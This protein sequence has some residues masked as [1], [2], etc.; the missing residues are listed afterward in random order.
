MIPAD[1]AKSPIATEPANQPAVAIRLDPN[2]TMEPCVAGGVNI[3]RVHH[4]V[5]NQHFQLGPAEH[6][7]A[8]LLDRHDTVEA[9]ARAAAADGVD[10]SPQRLGEFI[11]Q[12]VRHGLASPQPIG[13]STDAAVA[14][15]APARPS[16][17][18]ATAP[19]AAAVRVAGWVISLRVPLGSPHRAASRLALI[20]KRWCPRPV[21]WVIAA[22][23]LLT[24]MFAAAHGRELTAGT[25]TIIDSGNWWQPL[26]LWA[27]MKVIHEMGHAVAAAGRGVRVGRGGLMF[28]MMAP[29]AYVDVSDAW[30]LP[31]AADRIAIAAAGIVAELIVAAASFWLWWSIPDGG[32]RQTALSVFLLAGPATLLVNANPL[33]RLDGYYILS[34]LT[35][36]ANLRDQGRRL[37][38]GALGRPLGLPAASVPLDRSRRRIALS[39]AVASVMFQ[40]VWMG[41][42]VVTLVRTGGVTAM[43]MAAAAVALWVVL[44]MVRFAATFWTRAAAGDQAAGGRSKRSRVL[45]IYVAASGAAA[46]MLW[47]P[48][49]LPRSIP[50]VVRYADEQTLRAPADAFVQALHVSS[51]DLATP[52]QPLVRGSWDILMADI[53][54]QVQLAAVEQDPGAV[55]GELAEAASR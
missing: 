18:P 43:V 29:I 27:V 55:I 37:L 16:P 48:A 42:L 11:E 15:E 23:V 3:V 49:P 13:T 45:A 31:R 40:I 28:F 20:G 41:G 2:L 46:T 30:R 10:W 47:M 53:W 44:P 51:G 50:V 4:R 24:L 22:S 52:G 17:A 6:H 8:T 19:G 36:I 54:H 21:R 25:R 9:I 32:W 33:L 5:T 34:D 12:L 35:G 26:M 7:V 1:L 39:H 14:D 38:V